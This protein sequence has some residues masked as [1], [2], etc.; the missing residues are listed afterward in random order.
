MAYMQ[1][2]ID[3]ECFDQQNYGRRLLTSFETVAVAEISDRRRVLRG[4]MIFA[5][6]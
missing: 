3:F 4:W 1:S 6:N 5:T 2:V